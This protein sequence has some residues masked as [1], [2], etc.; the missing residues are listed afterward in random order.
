MQAEKWWKNES[1]FWNKK[2]RT[3]KAVPGQSTRPTTDKVKES[4]FNMIGP[5]FD[6]DGPLIYLLEVV[7]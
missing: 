3:L 7:V 2:G 1:D 4:I 5:Y 6:G